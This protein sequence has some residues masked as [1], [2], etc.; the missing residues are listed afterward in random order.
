MLWKSAPPVR[1]RL[2]PTHYS[3]PREAST[4][5]GEEDKNVPKDAEEF[6]LAARRN[7]AS[8]ATHRKHF[9]SST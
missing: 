6:N 2:V 8:V 9:S 3:E 5:G 4:A 1:S 7:A